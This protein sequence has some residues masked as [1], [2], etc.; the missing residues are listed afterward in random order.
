MKN[1]ILLTIL[2]LSFSGTSFAGNTESL[3]G[4]NETGSCSALIQEQN[5]Q[6]ESE[7]ITTCSNEYG[8]MY[9]AD[10]YCNGANRARIF[11]T[12]VKPNSAAQQ[13]LQQ[14]INTLN[15]YSDLL[16]NQHVQVD[17]NVYHSRTVN[18]NSNINVNGTYNH[19]FW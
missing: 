2:L 1:R 6:N 14:Q 13:Q 18:V 12:Y 17:N 9:V 11:I 8:F 7:Y 3:T 10:T 19:Y 15:N 4:C 16:R 5:K